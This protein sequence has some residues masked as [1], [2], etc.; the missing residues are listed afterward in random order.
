MPRLPFH[1]WFWD[2]D[3]TL[4]DTYPRIVRAFQKALRAEGIGVLDESVLRQVKITL[5]DAAKHFGGERRAE[6]LLRHYERFSEEEGPATL[7]PYPGAGEALAHLQAQGCRNY[8]Y[9]HR[10]DTAQAA[11]EAEGLLPLFRDAVTS[12]Q[13]FPPKPAPDAL[14]YLLG[15]Y[16]LQPADCV[17]VGD[18][19]IDLDAGRN[20]GMSGLLFDP[21]GFYPKYPA[22]ARYRS[23]ADILCDIRGG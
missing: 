2:F 15:K 10:G 3:G 17:M 8:L 9:T 19:P 23:Y 7:R 18:R 22:F 20:A 16:G 4:Y 6:A 14:K 1:H 5:G 21:E 13:G 12:R 11:L